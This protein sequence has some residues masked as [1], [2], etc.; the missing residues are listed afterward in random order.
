MKYSE[1]ISSRN[2][3]T[4]VYASVGQCIY[5]GDNQSVLTDEHIIPRSLNG[6]LIFSKASCQKCAKITC[7]IEGAVAR[8]IFGNF[9]LKHNIKT[10]RKKERPDHIKA[11]MANDPTAEINVP[12]QD[13]PAPLVMYKCLRAGVLDN[14]PKSIDTSCNWQFSVIQDDREMEK[15][16]DKYGKDVTFS[17]RHVPDQFARTLAKI[18]YSYAIA[19][20]GME[21]FKPL[22]PD[23]ILGREKN[24]SYLVG[25]N[26]ELS[27]PIPDAGH[28]LRLGI[29]GT[30]QRAFITVDI[31]LFASCPT[32]DYQVVVGEVSGLNNIN[33]LIEKIKS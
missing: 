23:L 15:F 19:N 31:R 20:I 27:P 5:C 17:F 24:L 2:P 29:E 11:G 8:S 6:I 32:P 33:F 9:R 10:R 12:I 1:H 30:V 25:G 21:V 7:N 14:V 16:Q 28:I 18:G 3:N 22:A 4:V 13:H 26:F